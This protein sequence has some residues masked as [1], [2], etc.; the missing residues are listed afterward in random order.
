MLTETNLALKNL[1]ALTTCLLLK[2]VHH[3][4][5]LLAIPTYLGL[6]IHL[7][8]LNV[9]LN[10]RVIS[11]SVFLKPNVGVKVIMAG[12]FFMSEE[13]FLVLN[14]KLTDIAINARVF[15]DNVHE[16]LCMVEEWLLFIIILVNADVALE[17]F[18]IIMALVLDVFRV[19]FLFPL[20]L[21]FFQYLFEICWL[22]FDKLGHF[23]RVVLPEW[24]VEGDAYLLVLWPGFLLAFFRAVFGFFTNTTKKAEIF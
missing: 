17:F 3:G 13:F 14:L 5:F 11:P 21:I 16:E 4:V 7:R 9:L 23:R 15:L 1:I 2:M 6:F 12:L 24:F 10:H 20:W 8:I 22:L 18:E 19:Y